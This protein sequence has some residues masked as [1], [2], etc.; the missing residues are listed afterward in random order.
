MR[1][2]SIETIRVQ[3]WNNYLW[4][5]VE[6]DEGLVGLGET[7]RNVGAVE[8]YI[9]ET[10]A[11]Y[12]LGQEAPRPL[13]HHER[14][15]RW[16]GN[17]PAGY[18]SRSVEVSG[19]SAIDFAL[20]DLAGKA[21]DK[22]LYELFGGPCRDKIRVYNTCASAGYNTQMRAG[23]TTR[24][25]RAGETSATS[26]TLYD[27]LE[28]QVNRPEELAASL[29]DMGI[30]AMKVWPLDAA[31]L[32]T[33]GKTISAAQ[34]RAGFAPIERIRK[35]HGDKIDIMLEMHALWRPQAAA[36]IMAVGDEF[37]L[38]WHEDPIEMHR[39]DD[40]AEL[41]ANT[42]TPIA[43]SENHGTA[44][45]YTEALAKR[46]VDYLHF[47]MAWIGGLTEGLRVAN[48]GHAH[49]RMI[50]PHDCT[51]PITLI[52]NL[53]LCLGVPN[54]LI[55]EMVRA[56][57]FGF[58]G[59]I[60]TNLPVIEDGFALTPTGPGLGTELSPAFLARDDLIR[61]QSKL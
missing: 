21:A 50:C 61:R 48:L 33:D 12:L 35:A 2:T 53:H 18:P 58:Y 10:V 27:D 29:L 39:L 30:T 42:S 6:T 51:G 11:P 3:E 34:L 24:L 36:K 59:D 19:N 56:Y 13:Y 28:A 45:W 9:H 60:A 5:R 1:I 15:S 7:F 41:R 20:W 32:D 52:A 38:F 37:G 4:V 22:P 40:L 49:D 14:M 25:I 16:M 17:H 26:N 54:A 57:L 31:A 46:A 47:D 8:A 43:G 23:H 55:L 44:F